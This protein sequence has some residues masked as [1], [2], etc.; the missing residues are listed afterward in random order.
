M[1]GRTDERTDRR[2]FCCTDDVMHTRAFLCNGDTINFRYNDDNDGEPTNGV[3][4]RRTDG[5]TDRRT[6]SVARDA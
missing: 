2:T 1:N 4:D 6:D 5:Q 3:T